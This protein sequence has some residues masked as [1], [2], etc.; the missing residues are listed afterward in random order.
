MFCEKKPEDHAGGDGE[1][2]DGEGIN[3]AWIVFVGM[4]IGYSEKEIAHMYFGKWADLHREYRKMHNIK[5][6][7]LIFEEEKK[8]TSLMDL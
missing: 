8:V 1:E 2:G 3:F 7:R 4:Q 5:V 6:K